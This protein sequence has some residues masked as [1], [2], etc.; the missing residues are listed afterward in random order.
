MRWGAIVVGVAALSGCASEDRYVVDG[1]MLEQIGR[2]PAPELINV[3]MRRVGDL[4]VQ[5]ACDAPL[6]TY[7]GTVAGGAGTWQFEGV[8]WPEADPVAC[9]SR[10]ALDRMAAHVA[11]LYIYRRGALEARRRS[12]GARVHVRLN[13][14]DFSTL[15]KSGESTTVVA[16]GRS[17]LWWP[18]LGLVPVG[19]A[20]LGGGLSLLTSKLQACDQHNLGDL[21]GCQLGPGIA[22]IWGGLLTAL[23]AIALATSIVLVPLAVGDRP[24]EVSA[25]SASLIYF[26]PKPSSSE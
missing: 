4:V 14:F 9:N 16:R 5:I 1:A 18:L 13:A 3:G 8:T 24:E 11:S 10:D 26:S 22:P 6:G 21:L 25:H 17:R 7:S 19:V 23:G 12:D 20:A 15:R 2:P